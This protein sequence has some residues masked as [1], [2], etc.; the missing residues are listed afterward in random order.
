MILSHKDYDKR[1]DKSR[2]SGERPKILKICQIPNFDFGPSEKKF[3][4][5]R[6]ILLNRFVPVS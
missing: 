2:V 1:L 6:S 4:Q 5:R 3:D